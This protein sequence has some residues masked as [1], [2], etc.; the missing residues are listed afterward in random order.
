[1]IKLI[2]LFALTIFSTN[3][4]SC[5]CFPISVKESIK[6][7]NAIFIG[8]VLKV[9]TIK[10]I[11]QNF[12][13]AKIST[14]DSGFYTVGH[15]VLLKVKKIFKGKSFSDTVYIM[16]GQG[17]G[18]CGYN[19]EINKNYIIYAKKEDYYLVDS[20]DKVTSKYITHKQ[21]YLTT[22]DCDRTTENIRKE[23]KLLMV[24]LNRKN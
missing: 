19:F 5:T 9:D 15:L 16:T 22:N 21:T 8:K 24:R 18:D 10:V 23:E 14:S 1:M 2:I 6:K 12:I 11:P 17:G 13:S 4:Y 7:S 3:S 20:E